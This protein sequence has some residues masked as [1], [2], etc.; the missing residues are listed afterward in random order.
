[1]SYK[2]YNLL[3][4]LCL[5]TTSYPTRDP[6]LVLIEVAFISTFSALLLSA[7]FVLTPARKVVYYSLLPTLVPFIS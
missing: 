3:I 5:S 2:M 1:M 4:L 7:N 6:I